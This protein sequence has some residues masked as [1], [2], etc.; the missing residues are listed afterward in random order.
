MCH[1]IVREEN[2]KQLATTGKIVPFDFNR[3]FQP[4]IEP[5]YIPREPVE[6]V[7]TDEPDLSYARSLGIPMSQ[8]DL[9]EMYSTDGEFEEDDELINF[10]D[11]EDDEEEFEKPKKKKKKK[12][13]KVKKELTEEEKA[14]KA[15]RKA[16]KEAKRQAE[17]EAEIEAEEREAAIKEAKRQE[18][19]RKECE[20]EIIQLIARRN[21]L[22][23]KLQELNPAKEKQAVQIAEMNIELLSINDRID[24]LERESGIHK[25]HIETGSPVRRFFTNV[26][27]KVVGF[28][29]K[30]KKFFKKNKELVVGLASVVLPFA[31]ACI[32]KG[33]S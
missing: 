10:S 29:S 9:Q 19:R 17:I 20:V 3:L 5:T 2:E 4:D 8:E 6:N 28:G 14:A 25:S 11:I 27:N 26:K 24:A 7:E 13:K 12:S 31:A 30:I 23:A 16:A 21:Y 22:N 33:V 1:Q 32:F 18:K 15:E